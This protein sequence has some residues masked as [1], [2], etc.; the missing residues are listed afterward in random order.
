MSLL[1]NNIH[2]N[3]RLANLIKFSLES[4]I[5]NS[6]LFNPFFGCLVIT[7]S[8]DFKNL[9]ANLSVANFIFSKSTIYVPFSLRVKAPCS[10]K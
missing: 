3:T 10:L 1:K 2:R 6:F 4:N 5:D 9:S 8:L 7:I